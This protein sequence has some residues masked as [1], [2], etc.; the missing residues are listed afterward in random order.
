M[1]GL[2]MSSST[3]DVSELTLQRLLDLTGR[4][5]VVTGG[6]AGI[7]AATVQ[8]LAEAGADV[9]VADI[10]EPA[11]MAT[12]AEVAKRSGRTVVAHRTDVGDPASLAELAQWAVTT[13]GRLDYWVNNA[14]IYPPSGPVTGVSD[15]FLER[16][17]RVNLQGTF[18]G[19]REAAR[20]MRNGGVIVNLASV[21]SFSASPGLSAYTTVK[22][23]IPGLTKALAV[24]LGGVGIRVLAVAPTFIDTPGTRSQADVLTAAGIDVSGAAAASLL[25]RAGAPD[26]IARV[27]LFCVSPMANLMTGSVLLADGGLLAGLGS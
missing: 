24:E 16:M 27:I 9:V 26:D 21:A 2:E 13:M 10:D 17:I 11:A 3:E 6:A 19:A 7:G 22:H 25:G 20:H 5:A 1:E 14:G 15:D 12:A 4:T 18:V 8:R 23:A